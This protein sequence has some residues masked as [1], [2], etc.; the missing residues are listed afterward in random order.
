MRSFVHDNN[1]ME[2][3]NKNYKPA[4]IHLANKKNEKLRRYHP[5]NTL[6]K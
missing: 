4:Y 5:G 3:F 2:S 6:F 1:G